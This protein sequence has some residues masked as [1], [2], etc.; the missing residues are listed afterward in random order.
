MIGIFDVA[1]FPTVSMYNLFYKI[2]LT[3]LLV[4][5]VI[6][7]M[8]VR[9]IPSNNIR[10]LV[11]IWMLLGAYISASVFYEKLQY[12]SGKAFGPPIHVDFML[13]TLVAYGFTVYYMIKFFTGY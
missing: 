4:L 11:Y 6:I 8:L 7:Y 13:F 3:Y 12:K 9:M 1:M 5:F 2:D 10:K